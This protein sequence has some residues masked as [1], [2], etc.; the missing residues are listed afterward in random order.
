MRDTRK[1]AKVQLGKPDNTVWNARSNHSQ[2]SV[3]RHTFITSLV[4]DAK[5]ENET[6]G[7]GQDP[8]PGGTLHKGGRAVFAGYLSNFLAAIFG[9]L[10]GLLVLYAT[11]T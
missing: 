2:R 9:A 11:S 6:A 1:R 8:H 5:F 4:A 3:M 7:A 10:I